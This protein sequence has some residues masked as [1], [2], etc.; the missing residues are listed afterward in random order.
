MKYFFAYLITLYQRHI[1]PRKG[2]RC[3]HAT[4]FGGDSCSGAIKKIIL[5]DGLISGRKKIKNRFTQCSYAYQIIK[6]KQEDKK[7]ERK[8]EQYCDCSG[9]PSPSCKGSPDLDCDL[10]CDC[11]F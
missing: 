5:K 1:S 11:S 10:P 6:S 4:H 7:E 2:F 8:C 3:A 9:L